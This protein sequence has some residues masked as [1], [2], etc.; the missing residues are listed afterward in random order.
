[1]MRYHMAFSC[2]FLVVIWVSMAVFAEDTIEHKIADTQDQWQDFCVY[3]VEHVPA[4]DVAYTPGVDVHG[5]P[6]VPADLTPHVVE[7]PKTIAFDLDIDVAKY[8]GIPVPAG[9]LEEA[10][11]GHISIT[12]NVVRFNGAPIEGEAKKSLRQTCAKAQE[13]RLE[14]K[15]QPSYKEETVIDNDDENEI[16]N[17]STTRTTEE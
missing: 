1:M 12:D 11:I 13:K 10:T 9:V 16:E 17:D 2:F 6:V 4:D 8:L 15:T 14:S 5:K 3:F 7:V